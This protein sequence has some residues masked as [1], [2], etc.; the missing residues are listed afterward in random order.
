MSKLTINDLVA[1]VEDPMAHSLQRDEEGHFYAVVETGVGA[2]FHPTLIAAAK[3][4][5]YRVVKEPALVAGANGK[6][7]AQDKTWRVYATHWHSRACQTVTCA[8]DSPYKTAAPVNGVLTLV[9]ETR[10]DQELLSPLAYWLFLHH[11]AG[12]GVDV[13]TCDGAYQKTYRFRPIRNDEGEVAY[14]ND[15]GCTLPDRDA[16]I[17]RIKGE[18]NPPAEFRT[19]RQQEAVNALQLA[20][21]LKEAQ[22]TTGE[23][24]YN[25]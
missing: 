16:P 18:F 1:R 6:L 5:G 10:P 12:T 23:S 19:E 15:F 22:K 11:S 17:F 20:D 14:W 7:E 21:E 2:A 3:R 25:W 8:G 4:R 13:L 9:R 24:R